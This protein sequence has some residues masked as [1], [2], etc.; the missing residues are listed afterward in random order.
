MH[1][2]GA[3]KLCGYVLSIGLQQYGPKLAGATLAVPINYMN[4]IPIWFFAVLL[5]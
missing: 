1:K 4:P 2:R 3:D 5:L